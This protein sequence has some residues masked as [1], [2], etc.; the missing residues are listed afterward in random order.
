MPLFLRNRLLFI[1]IPKCGGDTVTH[2][3]QRW[4]DPPFL[5]VADGSVLV[6][7]HTPQHMTWLEL[8]RA[9][10]SKEVDFRVAAL[11]RHPLDRIVSSYR[12]ARMHR[13]DWR[14]SARSPSSFL[15]AFLSGPPSRFDNHGRS[16]LEFLQD[17]DGRIDAGIDIRPIQD[18]DDLMRDLGLPPVPATSRKNVTRGV[19]DADFIP[20]SEDDI[21]RIRSHYAQDIAWFETRFPNIRAES[22]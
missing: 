11:V 20:F 16:L 9:G 12:Y 1:H 10:W 15:D 7:G 5:F 19:P 6:N 18:M 13:S 8:L 3:L 17:E 2:W 4:G 14:E 21:R 22:A